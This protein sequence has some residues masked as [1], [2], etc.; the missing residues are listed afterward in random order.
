MTRRSDTLPSYPGNHPAFAGHFPGRPIVPGVLLLDAALH[1]LGAY[2][3]AC[4]I[5]SA[6]FLRPVPPETILQLHSEATPNGTVRFS[7][8]DDSKGEVA[9]GQLQ[10]MGPSAETRP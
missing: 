9:T 7:V 6:K 2:E 1:A 8:C 4:R 5:A 10:V 3:A